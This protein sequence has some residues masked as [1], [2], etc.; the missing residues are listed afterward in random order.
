MSPLLL[1]SI[2]FVLTAYLSV[3]IAFA[4]CVRVEVPS[5]GH[6]VSESSFPF[7]S[8]LSRVYHEPIPSHRI[9]KKSVHHH[10]MNHPNVKA[11]DQ[12]AMLCI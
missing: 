3:H 7:R 11:N 2:Y 5:P 4:R 12:N 6:E 1:A 10:A 9:I 8:I